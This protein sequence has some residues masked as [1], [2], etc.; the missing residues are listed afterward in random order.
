MF[1]FKMTAHC[2]KRSESPFT[3]DPHVFEL[4]KLCI[5][6]SFL[7]SFVSIADQTS[8]GEGGGGVKYMQIV[9]ACAT[10]SEAHCCQITVFPGQI[11]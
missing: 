8:E 5:T 6:K 10:S 9:F 2:T 3:T 1:A 11:I 7:C 4:S